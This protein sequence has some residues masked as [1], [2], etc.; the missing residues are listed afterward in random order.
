MSHPRAVLICE[1]FARDGLQKPGRVRAAEEMGV[2]TGID[3]GRLI[4]LGRLAEEILGRELNAYV[5]KTGLA[6]HGP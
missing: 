4:E 6:R 2:R 1:C 5:V 3:V